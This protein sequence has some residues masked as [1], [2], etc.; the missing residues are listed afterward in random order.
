V[1]RWWRCAYHR[2]MAG[3]PSGSKRGEDDLSD[4][5]YADRWLKKLGDYPRVFKTANDYLITLYDVEELSSEATIRK[6]QT[7]Q[8]EGNRQVARLVEPYRRETNLSVGYR[9]RS[10]RGVQ[11]RRWATN[12]LQEHPCQCDAILPIDSRPPPI[13]EEKTRGLSPHFVRGNRS[14]GF[15]SS[16]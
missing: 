14:S 16:T 9:V 12:Q 7:V 10:R 13:V 3:I 6:F 15:R 8:T 4:R 1:I 5:G 2:L 11:F